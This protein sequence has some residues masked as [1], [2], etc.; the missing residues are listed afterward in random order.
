[1]NACHLV[2]LLNHDGTRQSELQLPFAPFPGLLLQAGW[3]RGE[4]VKIDA[5]F[6]NSDDGAFE[7]Y[8]EEETDHVVS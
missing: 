2:K 7:I 5:V 3:K 4:F 1:M 8:A 6:W